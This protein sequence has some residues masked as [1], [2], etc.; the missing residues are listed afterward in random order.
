V[1]LD[2]ESFAAIALAEPSF[3]TSFS[4][5]LMDI[6]ATMDAPMIAKNPCGASSPCGALQNLLA[7]ASGVPT[8]KTPVSGAERAIGA[9]IREARERLGISVAELG[10]ASGSTR[11]KVQFWERGAH[12]PPLRDLASICKL[13]NVD[14]NYILG[15]AS[16]NSLT[17]DEIASARLY[18]QTIASANKDVGQARKRSAKVRLHGSPERA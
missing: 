8:R 4:I 13:L 1:R 17:A 6:P 7:Y 3:F 15:F 10:L 5:A 2:S 9:R 18:I 11:Q 12:F 14:P 16:L